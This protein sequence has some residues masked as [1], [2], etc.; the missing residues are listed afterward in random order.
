MKDRKNKRGSLRCDGGG[1]IRIGRVR[2]FR[3][4]YEISHFTWDSL[5]LA[6]SPP[7]TMPSSFKSLSTCIN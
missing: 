5:S 6:S 2:T 3:M 1:Y 4:G 7:S